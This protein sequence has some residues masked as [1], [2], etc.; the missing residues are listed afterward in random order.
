M[1]VTKHQTV[2]Q[3]LER[4]ALILR[5]NSNITTNG[6]HNW[7]VDETGTVDI[8]VNQLGDIQRQ[9]KL[10]MSGVSDN[11]LRVHGVMPGMKK[12]GITRLLYENCNSLSNRICGNNKL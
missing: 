3:I 6:N 8:N 12:E 5:K 11:V 1:N 2:L 7:S 10:D 9:E 4:R